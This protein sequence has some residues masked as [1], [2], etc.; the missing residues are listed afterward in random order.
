MTRLRSLVVADDQGTLEKDDP[1]RGRGHWQ[2][3]LELN[4]PWDPSLRLRP[5][6][7]RAAA[8]T[9]LVQIS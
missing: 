6:F 3:Q 2:V 1:G 5:Q 9:S 8:A 4:E 7:V